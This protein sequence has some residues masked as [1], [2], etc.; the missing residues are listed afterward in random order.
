MAELPLGE[1]CFQNLFIAP[2]NRMKTK[3]FGPG[4]GS[5]AGPGAGVFQ[6]EQR[7]SLPTFFWLCEETKIVSQFNMGQG[8]RFEF[9]FNIL[10]E[11]RGDR[12]RNVPKFEMKCFLDRIR[13]KVAFAKLYI[14]NQGDWLTHLLLFAPPPINRWLIR[15]ELFQVKR[16]L[17]AFQN[18]FC[19]DCLLFTKLSSYLFSSLYL[20]LSIYLSKKSFCTARRVGVK[21]NNFSLKL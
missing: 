9:G 19:L 1:I 13:I 2:I 20:Y 18:F 3:L 8:N 5:G 21:N 15:E 10:G 4:V 11:G 17:L 6:D 14:Q 12:G 16:D 7:L